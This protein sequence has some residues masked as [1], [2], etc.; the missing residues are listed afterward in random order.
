M[1]GRR[2]GAAPTFDFS[3]A[4]SRLCAD[5]TDRVDELLHVDMSRIAVSFAQ[6]RRRVLHGLQAKLTPMRFAGGSLTTQRQGRLWTCQRLYRDGR[7]M[8]YILTFYLP[9]FLD[10]PFQEKMTTITHELFHVGPHFDGDLRRFGGRCYIHSR[11]HDDF[12]RQAELLARKYLAL[13]PPLELYEFLRYDFRS[14][15]R[16][17]GGVVGLQVP[18]PKL[19]PTSDARTA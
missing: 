1:S 12:D 5:I 15:T 8:L 14:L 16:R 17:H 11:S 6:T 2:I 9:R 7:E 18:I 4:M 13:R 19:I 3:Q 10:Q